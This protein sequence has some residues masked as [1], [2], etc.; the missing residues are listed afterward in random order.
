MEY[1]HELRGRQDTEVLSTQSAYKG[2]TQFRDHGIITVDFLRQFPKHY[3]EEV[4]TP[5]DFLKLLTHLL[6]VACITGEQYFMPCLLPELSSKE[7][8]KH[9]SG[10]RAPVAPILISFPGEWVSSG[11]FVAVVVFLQK[12]AR[13]EIRHNHG[14]PVCLYHNCV[15]FGLPSEPVV[16]TLIDSLAYLEV[17]VEVPL[18]LS[19]QVCPKVLSAVLDGLEK[20]ATIQGY[21]NQQIQLA[22]LCPQPIKGQKCDSDP[23]PAAI[24]NGHSWW[25]CSINTLV[26]GELTQKHLVWFGSTTQDK[27][28]PGKQT[29]EYNKIQ[30]NYDK[31]S[32]TLVH[33][34]L[35]G[36]LANKLFAAHLIS[37]DLMR[38]ANS[39]NVDEAIRTNH[40]LTA[41]LNQIELNSKT[42]Q[43]FINILEDYDQLTE[44]LKLLKSKF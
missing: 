4:F 16:V 9:R 21:D 41:V 38:Q 35:P 36:D 44:L 43:K 19:C 22:F 2:G 30:E 31:L 17:H 34:V 28:M 3:T 1:S 27:L 39:T 18:K 42:F 11:I 33:Q 26:N 32:S 24:N 5:A 20:A 25:T 12:E 13:W 37:E 7:I 6:I 29:P 40:L 23:H 14:T 15:Q 8:D 10:S